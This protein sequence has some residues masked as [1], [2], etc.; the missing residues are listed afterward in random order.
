MRKEARGSA[1]RRRERRGKETRVSNSP[2]PSRDQ[3]LVSVLGLDVL[4]IL[5]SSPRK[6]GESV[7]R[8]ELV[9]K[10]LCVAKEMNEC[11][12]SSGARDGE[13]ND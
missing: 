11:E 13:G 12:V 3:E 4:G 7:S 5:D 8:D 6:L 9:L 10:L 2:P 1:R